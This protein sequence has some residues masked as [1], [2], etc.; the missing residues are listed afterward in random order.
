MNPRNGP[1]GSQF[2]HSQRILRAQ[3]TPG[4]SGS[5]SQVVSVPDS[6][7]VSVLMIPLHA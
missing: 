4:R 2:F 5:G 3:K 7:S 6:G 1:T